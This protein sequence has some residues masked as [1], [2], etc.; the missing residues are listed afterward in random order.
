M[1]H[2]NS[3]GEICFVQHASRQPESVCHA[4]TAAAEKL[5]QQQVRKK[6]TGMDLEMGVQNVS[7][8]NVKRSCL[9]MGVCKLFC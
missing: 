4:K 1:F 8:G 7:L 2:L 3:L 6:V 9:Q 5:E